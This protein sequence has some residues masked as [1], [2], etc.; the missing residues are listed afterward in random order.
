MKTS[1]KIAGAFGVSSLLVALMARAAI[2]VTAVTTG[3]TDAATA[4]GLVIAALMAL[5][6]GIYGLTMVYRF[7]RSKAGA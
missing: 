5:S 6:V 1:Q 7:V 2:D 3:I 4:L